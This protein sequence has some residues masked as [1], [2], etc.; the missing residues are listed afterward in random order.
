MSCETG[1][2]KIAQLAGQ[3][4]AGITGLVSKRSFYA[5]I[6]VG[7]AGTGALALALNKIRRRPAAAGYLAAPRPVT[8]RSSQSGPGALAVKGTRAAPRPIPVGAGAPAKGTRA[9]PKPIPMGS[10]APAAKGT[11]TNPRPIPVLSGLASTP[12]TKLQRDTIQVQT[13]PSTGSRQ[14]FPASNSYRVLRSDGADTGLAITPYL[15]PGEDG[16]PTPDPNA[17]AVTHSSSGALVGGPYASVATAQG[18]ATQLA[19]LPW[20]GTMATEDMS[21]AKAII[22]AYQPPAKAGG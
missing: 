15:R 16:Q 11:R 6:A 12:P 2:T 7:A 3:V 19:N 13:A 22:A 1:S 17:W 18:L 20:T 21:R 8:P 4:S 5:G 9:R 14:P 10:G